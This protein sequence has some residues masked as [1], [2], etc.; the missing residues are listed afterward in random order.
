MEFH[1]RAGGYK[2]V[3]EVCLFRLMYRS[4]CVLKLFDVNKA[5]VFVDGLMHNAWRTKGRAR[6]VT[7][8]T[9]AVCRCFLAPDD[10]L[11]R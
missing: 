2:V 9:A 8:T 3:I 5:V 1:E 10:G 7:Q 6:R 4:L 11:H